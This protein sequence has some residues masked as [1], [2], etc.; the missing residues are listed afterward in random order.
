[1]SVKKTI[2]LAHRFDEHGT[3]T[4][5][6][7]ERFLSRCGFSVLAGEGYEARMIPSKVQDRIER[8]DI[9]LALFT[10]GDTTWISSEASFA[11]GKGKYIVFLVEEGMDVKKGI[12]GADYEHLTFPRGFVEKAFSDLLYA[13]PS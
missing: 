13:L 10:V 12:L 7:V 5:S 9:L 3:E 11:K 6:I 8:Q 2:F 1:M 4:A